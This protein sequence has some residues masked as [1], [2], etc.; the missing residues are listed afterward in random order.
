MH[1]DFYVQIKSYVK[2]H[3]WHHLIESI[4][5][6]NNI[7]VKAAFKEKKK[8]EKKNRKGKKVVRNLPY[9]VIIIIVK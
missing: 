6:Q 2:S 7:M 8:K 9:K 3:C 4:I 1:L 5:L